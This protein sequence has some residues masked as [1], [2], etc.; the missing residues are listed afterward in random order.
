[1]TQFKTTALTRLALLVFSSLVFSKF[2]Y[3]EGPA[4]GPSNLSAIHF[5]SPRGS[6]I[7]VPVYMNDNGPFDFLLD[8]GSTITFI[9]PE[10]LRS[11]KL[12]VIEGGTV[13]ALTGKTSIPLAIAQTVSVGPLIQSNVEL[14]ARDLA[15]LH[16]MDSKIRGVLG[17]N[18]LRNADYLIDYHHKTIEFDFGGSLA[19]LLD[20]ERINTIRLDTP[21][22][23]NYWNTEVPVTLAESN[24]RNINLILDT[25]SA[26]VVLFS[27]SLDLARLSK[28]ASLPMSMK[29]DTGTR[30]SVAEYP[31][32]IHVGSISL[33]VEARVMATGFKGLPVNGLLPTAGF[34]SVYISNSGG[35]VIFQPKRKRNQICD[36]S[37]AAVK[38]KAASSHPCQHEEHKAD[39][40]ESPSPSM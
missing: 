26:S 6:S 30:K 25:G 27:D 32:Q 36:T 19:S 15:G 4:A 24:P 11:L 35:F 7:V 12:D 39:G 20:G 21:D 3:A 5:Q 31:A 38:Q 37:I 23:P 2:L 34:G 29:D 28:R 10:L 9:D 8:T 14:G 13:T 17:Q 33:D 1:M 16:E 40:N 22:N 18:V